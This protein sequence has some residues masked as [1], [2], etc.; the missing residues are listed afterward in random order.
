MNRVKM[1]YNVVRKEAEASLAPP[2]P[3]EGILHED[4]GEVTRAM[5]KSQPPAG[6]APEK[7]AIMNR[8]QRREAMRKAGRGR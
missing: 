5:P 1:K 8:I 3:P 6:I 2:V 7:W 4:R